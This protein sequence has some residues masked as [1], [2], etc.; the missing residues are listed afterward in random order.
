MYGFSKILKKIATKSYLST[1]EEGK[2]HTH[3]ARPTGACALLYLLEEI[4]V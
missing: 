3:P 1:G 2:A 4:I